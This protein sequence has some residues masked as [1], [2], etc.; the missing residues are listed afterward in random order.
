MSGLR[1]GFAY[2]GDLAAPTGGY[3][4]D[5]RIIAELSAID[6][7]VTP[8][9]LPA[10][11]PE[12][13]TRDIAAAA[14]LLSA[15]A[16]DALIVDGLAF[17]ALPAALIAGLSPRP[18]ALVH[19][20]LFMET[21]LAPDRVTRL[22]ASERDA[23]A[24]APAILTTSRMTADIVAREFAV[25]PDRLF[26]AEPGVDAAPRAA[27]SNDGIVR[28]VAVGSVAP[29]KAY[30]DL[31]CALAGVGGDWRLQIVG[32]L[33]L[34]PDCARAL[35]QRVADLG[36]SSRIALAGAQPAHV[37]ADCFR[38]ADVFVTAS[39]FEGYGMAIAE[40]VARGLPVVIADEVA[41]AGA[42]PEGA[43]RTYPAGDVMALRAVLSAIIGDSSLRAQLAARSWAAAGAQPRWRDAAQTVLRAVRYA[44]GQTR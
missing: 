26:V 42:A 20:P 6:C 43:A 40:A 34:A 9:E 17:G 21:G 14:R 13:D 2:P 44:M 32:S 27:G 38:S 15:G 16:H 10:S 23:L 33:T 7:A 30:D 1:I 29:R 18:V 12:P 35:E 3:G 11:F 36:L 19:H 8:V 41:A 25:A 5:R 31:V 4:Y 22:R 37:V 39:H 28:L 24:E